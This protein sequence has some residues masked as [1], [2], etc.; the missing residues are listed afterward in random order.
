MRRAIAG[1]FAPRA[2][3]T[4]LAKDSSLAIAM[5]AAVGI[6]PRLGSAAAATF[7]AAVDAGHG[8]EDD[9]ILLA[10]LRDR[11]RVSRR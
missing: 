2:H 1:D 8:G 7:A 6:V 3:T 5:A 10:L 9:A 4:L 11:P